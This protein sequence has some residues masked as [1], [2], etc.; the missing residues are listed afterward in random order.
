V[1]WLNFQHLYYFWTTA[2]AGGGAGAARTL[3]LAQSTVS[4]QLRALEKKI[5]QKLFERDGRHLSLT[6]TGRVAFR[7]AEEIFV[8][9]GELR[10][11]LR[12]RAS[13]RPSRLVV[14]VSSVLSQPVVHRLLEPLLRPPAPVQLV[15]Y[16]ARLDRLLTEFSLLAIDVILSDTPIER[17]VKLRGHSHLLG[18][19]GVSFFAAPEVAEAHRGPFPRSLDGAPFLLPTNNAALRWSLDEWFAAEAIRPVVRGEFEDP[20]LL[21]TFCREGLGA[22]AAPTVAE[23]DVLRHYG[24]HLLGRAGAVRE[25]C[26]LI[27]MERELRHPAV[28]AIAEQAR[29]RWLEPKRAG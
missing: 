9:G 17:S 3:N 27:S 11:V 2:R 15:C 4:G 13:G 29:Q 21:A 25:R 24:V 5:G 23:S 12:G 6:E 19:S 8:L 20:T 28:L 16:Q 22:F 14:G 26:Y 18:E 10:D 1:N 7:Y